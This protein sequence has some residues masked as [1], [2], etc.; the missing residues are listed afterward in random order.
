MIKEIS[1]DELKKKIEDKE[2]FRLVEVLLPGLYDEWHIPGAV[3]IPADDI[4]EKAPGKLKKD[5]EIIVYCRSNTCGASDR[6][7][8]ALE[9]M[10]YEHVTIFRGGKKEWKEKKYP[11]ET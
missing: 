2:K 10:G 3:N 8:S 6:A 11:V 7:A 5:E 1:A 9:E 4:K